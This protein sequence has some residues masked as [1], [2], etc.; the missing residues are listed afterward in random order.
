[1]N[2]LIVI[3]ISILSNQNIVE[4]KSYEIVSKADFAMCSFVKADLDFIFRNPTQ[5]VV[6]R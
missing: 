1:M 3:T 2:W 6:I 4:P 5:T